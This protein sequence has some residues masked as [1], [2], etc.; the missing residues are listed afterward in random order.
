[1]EIT[2]IQLKGMAKAWWLV[3]AVR[4]EKPITWD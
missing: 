4:L 2:R 1:V 3:E